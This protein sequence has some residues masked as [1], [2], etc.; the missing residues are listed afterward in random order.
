[1]LS[2]EEPTEKKPRGSCRNRDRRLNL[3]WS[4]H[5]RARKCVIFL[6][7][8]SA[9]FWCHTRMLVASIYWLTFPITVFTCT[10]LYCSQVNTKLGH[11]FPQC[12]WTD[13]L[14]IGCVKLFCFVQDL[15][16]LFFLPGF[17]FM[18]FFRGFRSDHDHIITRNCLKRRYRC[19][20]ICSVQV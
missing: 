7:P 3:R 5:T 14:F 17:Y 9:W 12:A 8:Q 11:G 16:T 2:K 4:R 18:L 10:V 6:H 15:S 1:M 13:T 19:W 20:N